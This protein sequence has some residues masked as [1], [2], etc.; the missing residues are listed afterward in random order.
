M[1]TPFDD[2]VMGERQTAPAT[3]VETCV[4]SRP[5]ELKQRDTTNPEI[6]TV[7]LPDVNGPDPTTTAASLG[8]AGMVCAAQ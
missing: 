7:E 2:G 5:T 8:S 3:P 4:T 6:V 1:S